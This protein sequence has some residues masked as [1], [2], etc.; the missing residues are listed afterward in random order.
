[1][2][3]AGVQDHG[4]RD[5][6]EVVIKGNDLLVAAGRTPNTGD[7]D[8]E[9][10]DVERDALCFAKTDERLRTMAAG[11]PKNGLQFA[12]KDSTKYAATGGWG[13]LPVRRRQDG[14]WCSHLPFDEYGLESLALTAASA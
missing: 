6:S 2:T 9:L 10:A 4:T 13:L 11:P 7:S 8:P 14:R 12:V 1:M 5:G 3:G